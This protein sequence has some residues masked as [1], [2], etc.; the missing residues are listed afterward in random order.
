MNARCPY[1]FTEFDALEPEVRC[2]RC[3]TPHHR[4]CF[5]EHGRCV[6]LMC[7]SVSYKT[8]DGA[9]LQV[10]R[11]LEVT[12]GPARSPFLVRA[13][14]QYGE[15]RFLDTESHRPEVGTPVLSA[16][17]EVGLAGPYF[18]PGEDVVGQVS[19]ALPAAIRARAVRLVV[20]TTQ[21]K[22]GSF[23]P[24]TLLEREAVLA[25][26]PWEGHL[27]A[28][29]LAV[30]TF[31]HNLGARKLGD[32]ELIW[33]VA[34]VTRWTFRFKI[35]ELHPVRGQEEGVS[36]ENELLAYAD[37]PLASDIVGR[38]LLPIVRPKA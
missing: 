23:V 1:C 10:R 34:G 17:L 35:D 24:R 7:G 16:A 18:T 38:A 36:I 15:P 29:G 3:G 21:T 14:Y 32:D 27:A 22:A 19:L 6:T 5:T 20:R 2:G 31:M 26:S 30:R 12:I 9:E 8:L 37:V 25:G 13:G 28:L 33:L 11:Q 4:A